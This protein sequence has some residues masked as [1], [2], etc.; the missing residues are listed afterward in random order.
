MATCRHL[1]T[2]ALRMLSLVTEGHPEPEAYDAQNALEAFRDMLTAY[3]A[4]GVFG[5]L[6]NVAVS[7]DYTAKE[8]ERVADVSGSDVVITLPATISEVDPC[9]GATVTR[10]PY[11]RSVVLIAGGDCYIYDANHGAWSQVGALTLDSHAPLSATLERGLAALLAGNLAPDYGV[12]LSPVV[13]G[14]ASST[15]AAL[16]RK[17]PI[18]VA[19]EGPLLR[20]LGRG[21]RA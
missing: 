8:N 7:A 12:N 13:L 6:T 4:E 21:L 20:T 10:A 14:V 9:T 15:H 3:V 18:P 2:R 17:P 16:R 1:I 5:P 19:V 11:D